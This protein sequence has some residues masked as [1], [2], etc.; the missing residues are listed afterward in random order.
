MNWRSLRLRLIVGGIAAIILALGISGVGLAMLFERHVSRTVAQDLTVVLNHLIGAIDLDSEGHVVLA[1][2]PSDPRFSEPLSG[3]YWQVTGD[4]ADMLRSRSLWD[5]VLQLA[6]DLPPS[7]TVHEHIIAGPSNGRVL[8]VE[9][10]IQLTGGGQALP[11]R[12]VVGADLSRIAAATRAFS[13]DLAGALAILAVVLTIGTTTQIALG[14]RPLAALR[15]AI[16]EIRAG[17]RVRLPN[18]VP[19]E[20]RPL[21]EEVN[22]LLDAQEQEMQRSRDRAADLAHGFKTPLTVL[23]SDAERVRAH[24]EVSIA[25]DIESVV[26]TM[27]RHV[28]R[29]LARARLRGASRRRIAAQTA[30]APLVR[31]L[32]EAI[33]RTPDG[34]RISFDQVVPDS[35]LLHIDRADLAEMLGNLL[36]NAVRFAR[37]RVRIKADQTG[38]IVED[39]GPGISPE[40]EPLALERGVRLDQRGSG[41]GLGLA[42]VHEVLDAYGWK[43]RMGR[44]VDLGGLSVEIRPRRSGSSRAAAWPDS[45]L[46]P[47]VSGATAE[48]D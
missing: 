40:K 11:L 32:V 1:A 14:L 39:D 22:A 15:R 42:I 7:G 6:P 28:E 29:E 44:S 36:E 35:L 34:K 2:P 46:T 38:I 33:G 25:H 18:A 13:W 19:A 45:S 31:T 8:V 37:S 10:V 21:T 30:V 41:A 20:V 3:L 26:E 17:A 16:A 27:R 23:L 12:V 47:A 5:V 4:R 24:G 48:T 9:R 43:L